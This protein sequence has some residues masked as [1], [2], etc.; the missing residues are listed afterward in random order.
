MTMRRSAALSFLSPLLNAIAGV[1]LVTLFVTGTAQGAE[2]TQ[3][4]AGLAKTVITPSEPIWMAGFAI[5][6]H[7]STGVRQD[8]F[9]RALALEDSLG[10]T[11]VIATFDWVSIDRETADAIAEQC[12]QRFGLSRDRLIFNVSH[13]HSGPVAGLTLM[14]MYDDVV[15]SQHEVIRRYTKEAIEKSVATIG[16]ALRS[17]TPARIEFGQ[18][19]AGIAVNRRR[20]GN[21][22]RPGVVDPDVPVLAVKTPDGKV[23]GILIGYAAHATALNDYLIS[24]DW[25]GFALASI[26]SRFPGATALFIQGCGADANPLPRRDETVARLHAASLATSVEQVLAGSMQPL[27]GPLRTSFAQVPLAFQSTPTRD[28]LKKRLDDKNKYV[29]LHAARLL[30]EWDRD[31]KLATEYP[32]PIHVWKIGQGLTF[33]ALGGEVVADYSLRLKRQLGFD[34]TWVAGYSNDVMAYIPSER[35]L[36]EGGYEAG[37]AMMYFGRP[38]PFQPGLEDK[39]VQKAAALASP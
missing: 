33:V 1:L 19:L 20:L 22:A 25:P 35:V 10:K 12:R 23:T 26:E 11:A 18:G 38:A 24:N 4:K 34:T 17:L 6:T 32:Y 30:S 37:E 39:I 7:P 5:R 9:V 31:G 13:T 16:E 8:I 21:R 36:A 29:R 27:T 3:W 14:P 2:S 15:A 28:E